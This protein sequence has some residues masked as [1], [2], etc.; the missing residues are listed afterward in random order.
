MSEK[1]KL[2]GVRHGW[3]LLGTTYPFTTKWLKLRQDRV[4]L[5]GD[6]EIEFTYV[7]SQG[8][9]GIVPVTVDGNIVLI[10]QYRYTV[11]E[12]GFEIPAGGLHDT[13]DASMEQVAREELRQE[14][15][16][17]CTDLQYISFF[18]TAVGQSSQAFHVFLALDV[19]FTGQQT[20][21]PTE[22]IEIHPTPAKEALRMARAG[23]IRDGASAL[24]LLLCEDMLREH[25]YV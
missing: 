10:R 2:E 4:Q 7:E 23:E 20:L 15:G 1:N 6:G 21:E 3:R 5:E 11:D 12:V 16:A 13:G 22:R 17:T 19:N 24:S 9:V 8:A 14:V 25:G 18:Y